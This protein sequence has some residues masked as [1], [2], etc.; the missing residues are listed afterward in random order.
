MDRKIEKKPIKWANYAIV[1]LLLGG[2]GYF[3]KYLYA[4]SGTSRLNVETK[5]IMTDTVRRAKFQEMIPVSGVVLPIKNVQM[6]AVEKGRV[7]EKFIDDGAMV[8]K[9]QTILRLS[10][11][12]LEM[13]YLNQEATIVSQINQIR[14]TSL[15][16]EEQSLRLRENSLNVD[17]RLDILKRQVA[18]NKELYQD[19]VIAEV[20]FQD[21]E[22]EYKNLLAR[23]KLLRRTIHK[24]SLSSEMQQQQMKTTLDLMQ[25]NLALA[26]RNLDNLLVK[27]PIDGQLSGLSLELGEFV[28][29]GAQI[30]QIDDLSEFKIRVKIDE[31]YISRIFIQQKG[32]FDFASR[33][34]EVYIQKI[35]PQVVNG[36]FEADLLISGKVPDG[37][38][39]GQTFSIKLELSAEEEVNIVERG[40]FYQSTGGNWVYVIDTE[41]VA[42]RRDVRIGR[43]N[44]S[45]YEI[46]AGLSPG[47]VVI[48]SSYENFGEKDVLVLK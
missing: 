19:G 40:G 6:G 44:P 10:N 27:A 16:M 11:S 18:R 39:R 1:L 23:K 3:V 32:S 47:E 2:G 29:E 12:D 31:F 33:N 13:N 24:D 43:H 9:G 22:A 41:G 28:S 15:M 25:R 45:S 17:Y 37:I 20:E 8:Q 5:R 42:H 14:N 35:F 46:L 48:T 30:A 26:K 4:D 38:R 7:E 21:T 36:S 34:Y